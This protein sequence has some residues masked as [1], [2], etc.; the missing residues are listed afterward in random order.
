M[1]LLRLENHPEAQLATYDPDYSHNEARLSARRRHGDAFPLRRLPRLRAGRQC[2]GGRGDPGRGAGLRPAIPPGE[3]QESWL[4]VIYND[5]TVRRYSAADGA[6]LSEEQGAEPDR[7]LYEEFFTDH[8]K[9]TSP[10]HGTPAAYDRET[11]ELVRELES[12]A[13][14]TYVTQLGDCVVTEYISAQGQ[15]YGLLLDGQC[16]TLADLPELCDILADGTLVFDDMRGNLRQSRVY[17]LQELLALAQQ[18]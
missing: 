6:L 8:L 17:S 3:G 18:P 1:E 2:G 9:I 7:T 4:E 10:L 16:R 5:G 14:L 13:Y 12:D 15:R 11:G